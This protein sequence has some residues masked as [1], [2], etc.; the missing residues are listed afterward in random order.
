MAIIA[1]PRTPVK[2]ISLMG[3]KA[4]QPKKL[5][6]KLRRIR[7][8]FGLS[9]AGMAEAIERHGAKTQRGSVGSFEIGTRVPTVLVL[10]AYAKLAK[11]STDL[12][13]DDERDLPRGF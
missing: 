6:G 4:E 13:I 2:E 7:E 10:L 3:S 9:Q 1:L 5:A 12:L 11:I 8:K